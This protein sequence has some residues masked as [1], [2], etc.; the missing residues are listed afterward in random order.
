MEGGS[1]VPPGGAP[2]GIMG[3]AGARRSCCGLPHM[4]L[5]RWPRM[6]SLCAISSAAVSAAP[7]CANV[8]NAQCRWPRICT[9]HG[10][11]VDIRTD[12]MYFI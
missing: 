10:G 11:A 6:I 5:H 8:T 2:L 12:Y 1:T 9:C 3:S 7:R 4:S